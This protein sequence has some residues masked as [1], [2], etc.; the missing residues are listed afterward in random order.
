MTEYLALHC[1]HDA[2]YVLELLT[3]TYPTEQH[4]RLY[5][6]D[7]DL[8]TLPQLSGIKRGEVEHPLRL[9]RKLDMIRY[10]Q[11]AYLPRSI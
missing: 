8:P 1:H 9:D 4:H 10:H 11:Y 6:Q 7:L 3:P 5:L 2:K